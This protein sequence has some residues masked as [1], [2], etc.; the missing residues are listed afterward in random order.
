M[1]KLREHDVKFQEYDSSFQDIQYK[2]TV[3]SDILA[4]HS[5]VLNEHTR[6]LTDHSLV[7]S[8]HTDQL[9]FLALK[10]VEHDSRFDVVVTKLLEHDARFDRIEEKIDGLATKEDHNRIMNVLDGVAKYM[11]KIDEEMTM[12]IHGL[13]RNEEQTERNT[14]DIQLLKLT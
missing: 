14:K 9:E 12:L 13:R 6:L 10:V 3:H 1:D 7:L 8:Q 4:E 5:V 11:K 2:L